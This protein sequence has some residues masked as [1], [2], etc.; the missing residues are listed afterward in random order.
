MSTA[1]LT[2]NLTQVNRVRLVNAYLVRED[3]GLTL[4][5]TTIAGSAKQLLAAAAALGMPIRRIAV[6]HGHGDHVG[7]VDGLRKQ[8]GSQVQL[9]VPARDARIMAGDRTLDPGEGD[10]KIK[11]GWPKVATAP[12][13][14][15]APG[16]RVGSLEVVAS[17]GHTPGHVAYLDTRDRALICGDALQTLGGTTVAG[18]MNWRFPLVKVATWDPERAL[19]SAG[20]LR[21]LEPTMLAP[22]HGRGLANPAAEMD[23][24]IASAAKR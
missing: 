20:A 2:T 11:G 6:T 16:D 22:G 12:D 13:V 7:S 8:L 5:D 10:R 3:D 17:P 21:A 14:L 19:A 9:Y 18:Q 1:E 4:V 23:A 24:A 15:L